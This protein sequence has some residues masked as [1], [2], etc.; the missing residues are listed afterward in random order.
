MDEIPD[1]YDIE[2]IEQMRAIADELRVRICEL[3]AQQPMTATQVGDA[4]GVAPAK[5]HYHVRELERV[6]LVKLVFTREKSGI[7]EKYYRSVAKSTRVPA[8]LLQSVPQ[9]EMLTAINAIG[10]SAVTGFVRATNQAI[11]EQAE[12]GSVMLDM[13]TATLWVTPELSKQF[14]AELVALTQKYAQRRDVE[15]EQE[16]SFFHLYYSPRASAPPEDAA[17]TGSQ[18]AASASRANAVWTERR[19]RAAGVMSYSREELERIVASG[20]P[21]D[22]F[23]IGY[24]RFENDV[25]PELIERAVARFRLRGVLSAPPAVRAALQK[26]EV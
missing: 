4:L 1:Y 19:V 24:C 14:D 16:L 22:I 21:L 3:L 17:T 9:D 18:R 11:A 8:S 13:A 26:K 12:Q 10:Q 15:G 6:G 7:L 5:V 20:Q 2:S 23:V 25:T